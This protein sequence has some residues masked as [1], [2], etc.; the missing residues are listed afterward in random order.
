MHMTIQCVSC[1]TLALTK[2]RLFQFCLCDT[3]SLIQFYK[4]ELYLNY[5]LNL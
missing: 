4:T 2:C 1:N 3:M 5:V